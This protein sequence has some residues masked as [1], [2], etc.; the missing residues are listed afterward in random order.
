M[1]CLASILLHVDGGSLAN[2]TVVGDGLENQL[3]GLL[4]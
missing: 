3:G 1:S 4:C 2:C